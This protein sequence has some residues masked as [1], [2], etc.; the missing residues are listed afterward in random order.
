MLE[1]LIDAV[2]DAHKDDPS[3]SEIVSDS[4]EERLG[5]FCLEPASDESDRRLPWD[6]NF[7]ENQMGLPDYYDIPSVSPFIE[8]GSD[9]EKQG[10]ISI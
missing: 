3:Y 7:P 4:E 2:A 10:K 5:Y 8:A 6:P 9:N 1:S